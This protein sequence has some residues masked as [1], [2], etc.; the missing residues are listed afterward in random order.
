MSS[1]IGGH[2]R[3]FELT[4]GTLTYRASVY[5]ALNYSEDIT[6]IGGYTTSRTLNGTG[7]KQQNWVRRAITISGTGGLPP[8]FE[9]LNFEL[10]IT[11]R[12][13]TIRTMIRTLD[14]FVLPGHRTDSGYEPYSLKY[15]DGFWV[16]IE[17]IGVPTKYM[18]AYYPE[19]VCHMDPPKISSALGDSSIP[20][21]WVIQGEEV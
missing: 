12:C 6:R 3:W 10:P 9:D 1:D 20:I 21:S 18:R 7:I 15:V 16:P 13:G 8:G 19:L 17:T 5:E 11:V 2:P 14:A 4:D